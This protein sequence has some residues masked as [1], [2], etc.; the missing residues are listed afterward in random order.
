MIEREKLEEEIRLLAYELYEKSGFIPGR[1]LDNWLEAERILLTKYGLIVE[2]Q[3]A[4]ES[5]LETSKS[6]RTRGK[7][8]T[9]R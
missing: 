1:D 5:K 9:T 2:K 7:R 3:S 8:K 6:K 4:E